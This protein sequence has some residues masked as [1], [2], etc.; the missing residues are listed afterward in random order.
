[1]S[2]DGV[3]FYPDPLRGG[4]TE[5][6]RASTGGLH[7]AAVD[8]KVGKLQRESRQ[9]HHPQGI[10]EET[11]VAGGAKPSSCQVFQTVEGIQE[12]ATVQIQRQGVDCEVST[13]QILAQRHSLPIPQIEDVIA[14]DESE[15]REAI[16]AQDDESCTC[17]LRYSL[18]NPKSVA[19]Y[20]DVEVGT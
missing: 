4:S 8:R 10:L 1:M 20:Y 7:G 11:E 5:A 15:R 3:Q 19:G 17:L 6:F 2:Q 14:G 16:S 12:L 18:G 13:C 9:S